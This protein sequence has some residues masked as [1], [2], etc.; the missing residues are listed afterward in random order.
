MDSKILEKLRKLV[1]HE[2]SARDIGSIAEAEAF[3]TKVQAM[4]DEHN[5]GMTDVDYA[6]RAASEP[7]DWAYVN[8]DDQ[9]FHESRYEI[10]WQLRLGRAIAMCNNCRMIRSAWRSKNGVAFV[11]RTTDR[12]FA[13]MM[14]LYF[15][16]LAY[17]L[18]E[19]SAEQARGEQKFKYM[20]ELEPWQD[21]DINAFYKIMR[22]WKGAWFEGFSSAL[23]SRFYQKWTD[24]NQR[25][26]AG[27]GIVHVKKDQLAIADFL[28]GKT[29]ESKGFGRSAGLNPD[30]MKRGRSQGDAVNLTPHT[31]T[32]GQ[33]R[34][35][36]LLGQ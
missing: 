32:G 31:F 23:V 14:Y 6:E 3:A 13:K 15:M 11:G 29:R 25:M 5:I 35:D 34:N 10:S 26:E 18:N 17:D 27:T 36:R 20:N 8:S 22:D 9:G 4:M 1:A 30:G 33:A 19:K 16:D 24:T 7:I 2:R 12:E 21:Y 28:K